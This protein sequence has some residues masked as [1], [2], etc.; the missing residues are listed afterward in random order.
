MVCWLS[1]AGDVVG[2]EDSG[3]SQPVLE[4]RIDELSGPP[5]GLQQ[6]GGQEDV[7]G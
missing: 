1:E 2:W 3:L 6:G 4:D 5:A 7:A